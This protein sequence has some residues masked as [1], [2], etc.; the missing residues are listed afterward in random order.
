M[1]YRVTIGNTASVT[2]GNTGNTFTIGI[3]HTKLMYIL[4]SSMISMTYKFFSIVGTLAASCLSVFGSLVSIGVCSMT[5]TNELE[6]FAMAECIDK[7]AE[8]SKELF[9]AGLIS[10][11]ELLDSMEEEGFY[12]QNIRRDSSYH[13]FYDGHATI[14]VKKSYANY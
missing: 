9:E 6:V 1:C 3:V 14:T 7:E 4:F 13:C 12:R 10:W 2:I 11:E 5:T 8:H